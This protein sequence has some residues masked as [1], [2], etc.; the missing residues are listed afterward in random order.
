VFNRRPDR[1]DTKG[2]QAAAV[3]P[4]LTE[5]S[6]LRRPTPLAQMADVAAFLAPD[7]AGAITGTVTTSAVGWSTA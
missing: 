3:R 7:G 6:M 5:T 4:K 2:T 1:Q